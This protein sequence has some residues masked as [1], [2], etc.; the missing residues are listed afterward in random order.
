[1]CAII[2]LEQQH[3]SPNAVDEQFCKFSNLK[4]LTQKATTLLVQ[5]KFSIYWHYFC[6]FSETFF[7]N[8]GCFHFKLLQTDRKNLLRSDDKYL[9]FNTKTSDNH[10]KRMSF[11]SKRQG[12]KVGARTGE[13]I[14]GRNFGE[15]ILGRNF[16]E[17]ILREFP[18][19][20]VCVVLS[21]SASGACLVVAM[22]RTI[23]LMINGVDFDDNDNGKGGRCPSQSSLAVKFLEVQIKKG[24]RAVKGKLWI[25]PVLYFPHLPDSSISWEAQSVPSL[26][27]M[28]NK[29]NPSGLK[30]NL[31]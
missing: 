7:G 15:K 11:H 8:I 30:L 2:L 12:R 16:G 25:W 17:K 10:S 5:F 21:W 23:I 26:S 18:S 14:L 20:A 24:L 9:Y 6:M 3:R 1:M 4:L 28:G 27:L 22:M 13:K 31:D 19:E 29:K